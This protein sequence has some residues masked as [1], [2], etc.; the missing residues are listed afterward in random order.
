MGNV[1][2][3]SLVVFIS[4]MGVTLYATIPCWHSAAANTAQIDQLDGERTMLLYHTSTSVRQELYIS[5][6]NTSLKLVW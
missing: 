4:A 1:L 2:C 5:M 6:T 3:R